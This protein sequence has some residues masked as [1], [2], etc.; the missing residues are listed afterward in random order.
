MIDVTRMGT[1]SASYI[2]DFRFPTLENDI[3]VS[4]TLLCAKT[5]EIFTI[6]PFSAMEIGKF[7]FSQN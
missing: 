3:S 6:L 4:V 2:E 1:I 7:P 5:A